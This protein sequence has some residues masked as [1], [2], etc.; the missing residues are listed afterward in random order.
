MA[1]L[2]PC[3]GVH[4]ALGLRAGRQLD[5]YLDL[6][7]ANRGRLARFD[8]WAERVR[9]REE[10]LAAA[11]SDLAAFEAG[12]LLPLVMLHE[13]QVVGSATARLRRT[14]AEIGY[15]ID[16]DAEGLGIAS[17][18]VQ[19]LVSELFARGVPTVIARITEGNHRSQALI[20]RAGFTYRGRLPG[21]AE[22]LTRTEN[23]VLFSADA[24]ACSLPPA[25]VL[26]LRHSI[27]D[28]LTLVLA[29]QRHATLVH[30]LTDAGD[31][32]PWISSLLR[33]RLA[34]LITTDH[35]PVGLATSRIRPVR[36]QTRIMVRITDEHVDDA[37]AERVAAAVALLA[38]DYGRHDIR[39]PEGLRAAVR[40]IGESQPSYGCILTG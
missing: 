11:A 31:A 2:L 40:F 35:G 27:S 29:E 9:T 12:R 3:T 7:A 24:D 39:T 26:G 14:G 34:C 19:R 4:D 30:T 22:F 36:K 33:G 38:D 18:T 28:G 5:A 15:W 17:R 23:V 13:G 1:F 6:L 25:D 10:G 32:E 16:R 21:A 37:L 8:P 20:R